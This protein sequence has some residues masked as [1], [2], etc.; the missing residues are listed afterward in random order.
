MGVPEELG[1]TSPNEKHAEV[2]VLRVAK[3]RPQPGGGEATQKKT[4]EGKVCR[5][6]RRWMGQGGS[7]GDMGGRGKSEN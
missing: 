3:P 7:K 4:S 6:C 2:V 5:T 1:R